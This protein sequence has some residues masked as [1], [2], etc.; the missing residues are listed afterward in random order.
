MSR[1]K[2]EPGK[3]HIRHVL[4]L[5]GC[6]LA[7]SVF[8]T[9]TFTQAPQNPK[10]SPTPE[11]R[12]DAAAVKEENDYQNLQRA[13]HL[14]LMKN[15]IKGLEDVAMRCFARL[16][17]IRFIYE[18]D[19]RG[20][21][22]SA[23]AMAIEYLD[24]VF[25]NPDEIPRADA[26]GRG[27]GLLMVLR[28]KSPDLVKRL[29]KKYMLHADTS[30]ADLM[31]LEKSDNSKEIADRTVAKILRGEVSDYI[32]SIHDRI[33]PVDPKSA[34]RILAALLGYWERIPDI[35][36]FGPFIDFIGGNYT[37]ESA[38][39]ELKIRYCRFAV[40]L[41]RGQKGETDSGPTAKFILRTLKGVLP[42]IKETIPDL[43]N[44]AQSIYIVLDTRLNKDKREQE[45]A[46]ARIEAAEDKLEQVIAEAE[47]ANDPKLKDWFWGW[48]ARLAIEKKKLKLAVDLI[49]KADVHQGGV[50]NGRDQFL[51][52]DALP[53]ILKEK[54]FDLADYTIK[55]IGEDSRRGAAMVKTA[56]ALVEAK[57]NTRAFELIMAAMKL[58]E[59]TELDMDKVYYAFQALPAALKIERST[60]F[61]LAGRTLKLINKLS[62]P[63]AGD[64]IG[65]PA[66]SKYI[67]HTLM[68]VAGLLQDAFQK[69]AKTDVNLAAGLVS[70]I[71]SKNWR[72]VAEI[73]VETERKYPMPPKTKPS[74]LIT[75]S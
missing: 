37:R 25:N 1:G 52:V 16:E 71:Q 20:E 13:R 7:A 26:E 12:R 9:A 75:H 73:V 34:D 17:V 72:L 66:R 39:V 18:N 22:D 19:V 27:N 40:N 48:A 38:P 5:V 53:A 50:H 49:M 63:N 43:F 2:F 65:T 32:L 31:E 8:A 44:E 41:G 55:Q 36:K 14:V 68:P 47:A 57:D 30:F 56:T 70:D 67:D 15:D 11:Q 54:D 64:R 51:F 23:E 4:V 10:Q 59:N 33:R 29:E 21:F 60:G 62:T 74:E 42:V 45:E 69:L 58:F 28:Q 61:D 6:L 24:D 46:Y 3:S 35:S